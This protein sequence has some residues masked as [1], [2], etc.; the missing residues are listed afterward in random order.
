MKIFTGRLPILFAAMSVTGC[1]S[2]SEPGST[3]DDADTV[4]PLPYSRLCESHYHDLTTT[5]NS[6]PSHYSLM[7]EQTSGTVALSGGDFEKTQ[8]ENDSFSY[9]TDPM[10]VYTGER[11]AAVTDGSFYAPIIETS[12]YSHRT[13]EQLSVRVYSTHDET[14][15]FHMDTHGM[16]LDEYHGSQG[17]GFSGHSQGAQSSTMVEPHTW[18]QLTLDFQSPVQVE[19]LSSLSINQYDDAVFYVDAIELQAQAQ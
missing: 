4:N 18:V 15:E 11:S 3:T 1:M 2:E 6:A 8:A 12:H 16:M 9:N 10:Y 13:L 7:L 17:Q 14:V 5:N 19:C